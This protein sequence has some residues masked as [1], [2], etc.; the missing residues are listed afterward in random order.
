MPQSKISLSDLAPNEEIR[1]SLGGAEEFALSGKKNYQT[2]D[3]AVI[4]SAN[5]HAWLKV[6]RPVAENPLGGFREQLAPEED[7]LST[8]GS[9]NNPND[10]DEAAKAEA[11]KLEAE[12]VNVS[13]DAN[14]NQSEPVIVDDAVAETLAADETSKT[15]KVASTKDKD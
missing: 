7:H 11:A 15:S 10:P 3:E 2:D 4:S 5:A 12:G 13:I 1:F 9:P 8:L 6:E 14:K